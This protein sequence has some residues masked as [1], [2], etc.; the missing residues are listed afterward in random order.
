M[1]W[2]SV[3][4]QAGGERGR[5]RLARYAEH[6]EADLESR[7][8]HVARKRAK[9]RSPEKEAEDVQLRTNEV[10][11]ASRQATRGRQCEACK[12]ETGRVAR[13]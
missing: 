9:A 3:C 5:P 8:E 6:E 4:V 7:I 2:R 11:R 10:A 12:R 1:C 13:G